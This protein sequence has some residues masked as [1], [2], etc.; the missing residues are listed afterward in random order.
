MS[1]TRKKSTAKNQII[2]IV[3]VAIL[4]VLALLI[5]V[6]ARKLCKPFVNCKDVYYTVNVSD[7]KTYLGHQT[8]CITLIQC[9]SKY[10]IDAGVSSQD[11]KSYVS[12]FNNTEIKELF[13]N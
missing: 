11:R 1:K 12:L 10:L 9:G 8:F 2:V 3:A 13:K 7:G 6:E 5:L 4:L